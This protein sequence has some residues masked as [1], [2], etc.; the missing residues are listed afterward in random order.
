[1]LDG[2]ECWSDSTSKDGT[3]RSSPKVTT[4][5]VSSTVELSS[6]W[7]PKSLQPLPESRLFSPDSLLIAGVNDSVTVSILFVQYIEL[8]ETAAGELFPLKLKE[9][10]FVIEEN[11]GDG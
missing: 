8:L 4:G 5:E 9:L 3:G 2:S 10:A 7:K 6:S 1:M 11:L